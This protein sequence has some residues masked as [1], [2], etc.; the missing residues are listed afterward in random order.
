[1][2]FMP[3]APVT[4]AE[5]AGEC[6]VDMDKVARALR[7]MTMAVTVT[8]FMAERMP[9]AVH[10]DHTARPQLIDRNT[11][12]IYYDAIATYRTLTGLPTVINT[13]FNMH[14]E[15]I[16]CTP[17]EGIDAFLQSHLDALAIGNFLVLKEA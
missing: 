12:P 17:S 14:E 2:E 3:F 6:Y 5:H 15:P 7:F 4:L 1:T 8:P 10:V 16:V 9:A 13:S 11:N